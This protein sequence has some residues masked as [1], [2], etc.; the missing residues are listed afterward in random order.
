MFNA[1]GL[2]IYNDWKESYLNDLGKKVFYS[3][4]HRLINLIKL[5]ELQES[6]YFE[7]E[8]LSSREDSMTH[9]VIEYWIIFCDSS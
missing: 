2:A 9:N 8:I 6:Y 7:L 5:K 1:E 4:I 3:K